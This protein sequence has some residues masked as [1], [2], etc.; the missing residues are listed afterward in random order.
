MCFRLVLCSLCFRFLVVLH[1]F[2]LGGVVCCC[3]HLCCD[4]PESMLLLGPLLFVLRAVV[5]FVYMS[6]V[7]ICFLGGGVVF[8]LCFCVFCCCFLCCPDC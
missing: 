5:L 3:V 6:I 2:D 8:A 1:L 4:C 7:A